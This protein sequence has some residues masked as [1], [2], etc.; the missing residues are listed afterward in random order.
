MNKIAF[1]ALWFLVFSTAW[2]ELVEVAGFGRISRLIGLVAFATWLLS[3]F[4]ERG[5]RRLAP[6]HLLI[7]L[8]VSWSALSIFWSID[9]E[10]T[11]RLS[12]TYLQLALL[13]WLIWEL[14]TTER[15]QLL[16]LQGYVL[17][18]YLSA[19]YT[20]VLY[21]SS[22]A[23]LSRYAASGYNPN[24]LGFTL[25]LALP[26][27][28]Y[29]SLALPNRSLAWLNRLYLPVGVAAIVLTASRGA[30][31]PGFVALLLIPWTLIR[32]RVLTRA[33]VVGLLVASAFTITS[34]APPATMAR[35]GTI[36][37]EVR[38]GSFSS[39]A[40]IWRAGWEVFRDDPIIGVGGG[41]FAEAVRPVLGTARAPH[42]SFLPVLVGQGLIGFVLFLAIFVVA[43]WPIPGMSTLQRRFWTILSLTL[44]IGLLP[45]TW[46]YRKPTW[47]VLGVLIAAGARPPGE[48]RGA[49]GGT[50]RV[51]VRSNARSGAVV[52]G[53]RSVIAR[54][55]NQAEG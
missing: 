36:P 22:A 18:A 3:V 43:F 33:A 41:T 5:F 21:L 14:A 46:D 11:F 30:A 34:L 28:W 26:V 31:I 55:T 35:L 6:A 53:K 16:L 9:P 24:D 23:K 38:E 29:L 13:V 25:V 47:L 27:A 2:E 45:R 19:G 4:T 54:S 42:Q 40:Q 48:S 8:F 52:G 12:S 20:I 49:S 17:G 44:L 32:V 7:I 10:S 50:I 51:T 39:R 1:L 37:A 15:R